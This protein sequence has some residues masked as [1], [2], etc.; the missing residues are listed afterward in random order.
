VTLWSGPIPSSHGMSER[1]FGACRFHARTRAR[2][3]V[4][5]SAR[6][7][8]STAGD[9]GLANQQLTRTPP[10]ADTRNAA[11]NNSQFA[12]FNQAGLPERQKGE[13]EPS[14]NGLSKTSQCASAQAVCTPDTQ[15]RNGLLEFCKIEP[16]GGSSRKCGLLD[17]LHCDGAVSAFSFYSRRHLT[18]S[19]LD[20][21]HRI[22]IVGVTVIWMRVR[23][24][25]F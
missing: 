2:R 5:A 9:A 12:P 18:S 20:Y 7:R 3:V 11:V 15:F 14:A 1:R 8:A 25:I 19:R 24:A 10:S 22:A 6:R 13:V 23:L 21:L 16:N 4:F 17:S